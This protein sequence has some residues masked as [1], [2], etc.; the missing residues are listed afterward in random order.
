M[1]AIVDYGMG[2]LRSVQKAF[3]YVGARAE[4]VNQV[5]DIKNATHIV[6][7]G[8]G[9]FGDAMRNIKQAELMDPIVTAISAGRPFL[10]ICLGLQLM[11]SESEEMG[12]TS[13]F[14]YF[15]RACT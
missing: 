7:P 4:I 10:G 11:F 12:A 15:A 1:I 6:L 3:Q 8:V 5:E 13:W 2:N 14:G 9:A